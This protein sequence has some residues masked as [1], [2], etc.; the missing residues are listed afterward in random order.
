MVDL[1]SIH[2]MFRCLR[3]FPHTLGF[4]GNLSVA[5]HS[6]SS[7]LSWRVLDGLIQVDMTCSAFLACWLFVAKSCAV[8]AIL[9]TW[10]RRAWSSGVSGERGISCGLF[11]VAS[12]FSCVAC[13][14]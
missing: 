3:C 14:F 5:E 7:F 4:E 6:T 8:F 9:S 2:L 1:G 11:D 13:V 12:L 10:L